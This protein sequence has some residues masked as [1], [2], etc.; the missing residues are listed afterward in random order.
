MSFKSPR[1]SHTDISIE[2]IYLTSKEED[3]LPNQTSS[4]NQAANTLEDIL[5]KIGVGKYN[6]I[7]NTIVALGTV[8]EGAE[9]SVVA[10]LN[11][12]FKGGYWQLSDAQIEWLGSALFAGLFIGS[13]F[14]G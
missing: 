8:M 3:E 13:I 9:V 1:H 11:F 5:I 6:L 14:S 12:V 7:T 2:Q 4:K 10:I